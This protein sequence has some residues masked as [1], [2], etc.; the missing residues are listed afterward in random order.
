[1]IISFNPQKIN[2]LK[3][4]QNQTQPK[5]FAKSYTEKDIFVKSN[6]ISFGSLD[7][8]KLEKER[9]KVRLECK[10]SLPKNVFL[11][12]QQRGMFDFIPERGENQLKST[13]IIFLSDFFDKKWEIVEKYGLLKRKNLQPFGI[14]GILNY[15]SEPQIQELDKLGMLD[16]LN[17]HIAGYEILGIFNKKNFSYFKKRNLAPDLDGIRLAAL[18]D[19]QYKNFQKRNL[20]TADKIYTLSVMNDEQYKLYCHLKRVGKTVCEEAI[21]IIQNNKNWKKVIEL[22][23][24]DL[25]V[26]GKISPETLADI[27]DSLKKKHTSLNYEVL[28]DIKLLKQGKSV[29]PEFKQGTSKEEAFKKT[30]VG[31]AV[32]IGDK[33]YINDGK[34]LYPWKMT[35]EKYNNLFPPIERYMAEQGTLSNCYF[36]STL[37]KCM[38]NPYSRAEIYK[39]FEVDK[40]DIYCTIRAYKDF[41]GTKKFKSGLYLYEDKHLN[42]CKGLQI[43]EQTYAQTLLS[44]TKKISPKWKKSHKP[45]LK[46]I[47]SRFNE[48]GFES[49][50]MNELLGTTLVGNTDTNF[51]KSVLFSINDV[52]KSV[53]RFSA[54]M[55]KKYSKD[56]IYKLIKRLANDDRY[57]L[58][59][60]TIPVK[61]K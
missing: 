7:R 21:N 32:Q 30:K 58:N 59:V 20:K 4:V 48:G 27:N 9:K 37:R 46:G 11:K 17:L 14:Y 42:G 2:F 57:L 33:M 41:F 10:K 3:N 38:N 22:G 49:D 61:S 8:I 5:I 56:E 55:D 43:L 54:T 15:L 24:L 18:S 25:L 44:H 19:K 31:D 36:I 50:V 40:E 39:S 12:A 23:I 34:T 6:N 1:M 29:V 13:E 45:N 47:M 26:L 53:N 52:P 28:S 60:T 51:N 16:K 35:R